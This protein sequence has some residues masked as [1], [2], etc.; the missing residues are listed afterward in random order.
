GGHEE[1]HNATVHGLKWLHTGSGHGKSPNSGWRNAQPAGI[2]EQF[3]LSTPVMADMGNGLGNADYAWSMDSSNDGW[4]TGMWGILRNYTMPRADLFQLPGKKPQIPANLVAFTLPAAERAQQGGSLFGV[5]PITAPRRNYDITAVLANKALNNALGVAL[6]TTGPVATNNVGAR[7]DPAGGTLIYN[8]R[9]ATVT[10]TRVDDLTG[11]AVTTTHQGPLHDPTALMYV[12]TADLDANGK[13]LPTA[14]VEPLVLRARPG[15]CINVTV[16]NQL[17]AI[18]PDLAA[19]TILEGIVK[20]DRLHPQGSTTFNNNLIRASSHVGLH[21]QLVEYDVTRNDGSNVGVNPVQTVAPGGQRTYQWYAGDLGLGAVARNPLSALI[22]IVTIVPTPIEFG[23]FNL[24]PAD[25]IKQAAK[26]LVGAMVVEPAGSTWTE[27]TQVFDRQSGAG[28][29]LTRA[30]ATVCPSGAANCAI[31]APN[32]FRDFSLVMTKAMTH[33]YKDTTP[34]EHISGEGPLPEDSADASNMTVNY[35]TE[36]MWFRFGLLPNAPF[37]P[38]TL[39]G[40]FASIPNAHAAFSNSIA[41]PGVGGTTGDP[42]TP[43]MMASAGKPARIH[44][45]S[46][47]GTKRG[48]TFAQ[49][50]HVWQRDPYICPGEA[51]NKLT[52]SCLPKSVGSRALGKNPQGFAQGGQESWSGMSHFDILLPAAGGGNS[53]PGDYLFRDVGSFGSSS[54]VWGLLRVQ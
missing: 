23:G 1:E 52:G 50:G 14:P 24:T 42:V 47:H 54:G 41:V 10:G 38:A 12:R 49:H 15:E 17:P 30:Q 16:R 39:P 28:T 32:A 43:V 46:P 5:C 26:S 20:R 7:L 21:P 18:V 29:R 11:V 25:K 34:V 51:R 2:S 22:D 4:W 44:L 9:N 53:V 36:P 33:F 35:G 31:T 27:N 45:T 40:S 8:H 13:L 48:S 6:P 37:G 3:T 19:Y